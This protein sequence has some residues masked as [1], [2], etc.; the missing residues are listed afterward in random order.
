MPNELYIQWIGFSTLVSRE[1]RR[2]IRIWPQTLLPPIITMLLYFIV[3]GNLIGGRIG[4]MNQLPYINFITPGLVMMSIIN[5]SYINVS[6]SFFSAK[7]Q[8][9]IEELLV[10]P[11]SNHA[12]ILGYVI[13]G[14]FR[15]LITATLTLVIALFFTKIHIQNISLTI[16]MA[17]LTAMLF[18]L[19]GMVNGVFAKKFDDVAIIPMFILTPLTYL[20]GVFYSTS[21]LPIFWQKVSLANPI[22]YIINGFRYAIFGSSDVTIALALVI[23]TSSV[24]GLYLLAW[25]LMGRGIGLKR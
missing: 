5:N 24:V 1:I 2:I 22:L 7:F 15:G 14:I 12:I 4:P 23:L 19:A 9:C 6:S 11:M 18:S 8:N 17:V 3:F 10:S 16:F 20:G 13:S 21:L 25:Y